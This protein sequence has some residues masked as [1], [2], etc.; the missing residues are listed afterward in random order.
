[1]KKLELFINRNC[2]L[3]CDYCTFKNNE[4]IENKISLDNFYNVLREYNINEMVILGGEPT[5]SKNLKEI[6]DTKIPTS[7]YTNTHNIEE[8]LDYDVHWKC[9]YHNQMDL[10][11]FIKK[12][13]LLEKYNKS[14]QIILP[15]NKDYS[16][17]NYFILKNSFDRVTV[18]PLLYLENNCFTQ[19]SIENIKYCRTL[20]S[21]IAKQNLT[22]ISKNKICKISDYQITYDLYNN[23][24]Y[25]C[26]T[27][28]DSLNLDFNMMCNYEYCFCDIEYSEEINV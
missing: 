25:K 28:L 14:Y 15:I 9:S 19:Q 16:L 12:I 20:D 4:I 11:I 1:M 6:L 13:K 10:S 2:N 22:N 5:L 8:F 18:E 27:Y 26:L 3:T 7:I 23:K 24:L 17:L 21:E